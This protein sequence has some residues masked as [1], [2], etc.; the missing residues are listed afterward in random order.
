MSIMVLNPSAISNSS[1]AS[2]RCLQAARTSKVRLAMHWEHDMFGTDARR[3]SGFTLIELM[4]T[5][6]IAAVAFA[7]MIPLFV[8]ASQASSG[9]QMRT[10]ATNVAQ[11]QIEKL[12]ALPW[13]QLVAAY[14]DSG[15]TAPA[16][17]SSFPT[18]LDSSSWAGGQFGDSINAYS[19]TVAKVFKVSYSVQPGGGALTGATADTMNVSVTVTW[20]GRPTPIMPITVMTIISKQYA[21]PALTGVGFTVSPATGNVITGSPV[22]LTAYVN[23]SAFPS[24]QVQFTC[25][26][27]GNGSVTPA[28][29]YSGLTGTVNF[30]GCPDGDYMITA[31]AWSGTPGS[32]TPGTPQQRQYVLDLSSAPPPATNLSY[33]PGS[34]RVV[35]SWSPS[36]ASD[37]S[38]YEIDRGTTSGSETVLVGSTT[39]TGYTDTGLTNEQDYYYKVYAI[40]TAGNKSVASA[41]LDAVPTTIPSDPR[42]TTPGSFAGVA[43]QN[44]AVLSWTASSH[45][46]NGITVAGYYIYRDGGTTPCAQTGSLGFSDTVGWGA[47]HTYV[48]RA[49]DTAGRNSLPSS[50]ITVTT[51]T[52]PGP[53]TMTITRNQQTAVTV[54]TSNDSMYPYSSGNLTGQKSITVSSLYYGSYTVTTTY[55]GS[56]NVQTV[57]PFNANKT[58]T[59]NF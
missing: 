21:G 39:A 4:I 10:I 11:G 8:D 20:T 33:T 46:A 14:T 58:V 15:K 37:F 1:S 2:N 52:R 6:I 54:V 22:S 50:T 41:E 30:S 51:G 18:T 19:G 26:Y 56:T 53:Y 31:Q 3:N 28:V 24:A 49:Y 23:S 16:T 5:I 34:G 27:L 48:V 36:I 40:D 17:A 43:N 9:N 35:L 29:T 47:T 42:P 12:R 44:L 38:H 25:V 59:V 45:V 13:S 57:N 55:S 32:S 7:G